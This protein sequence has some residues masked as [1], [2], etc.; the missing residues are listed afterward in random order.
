MLATDPWS[1]L[2]IHQCPRPN[3]YNALLV[4][5]RLAYSVGIPDMQLRGGGNKKRGNCDELQL[6]AARRHACP[7]LL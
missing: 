4:W 2:V 7:Y 3:I 6:E 5:E 1:E